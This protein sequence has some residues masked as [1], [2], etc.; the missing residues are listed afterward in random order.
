[1]KEKYATFEHVCKESLESIRDITEVK[2]LPLSLPASEHRRPES[3][4]G[5][6]RRQREGDNRLIKHGKL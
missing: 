6:S 1:M 3:S 4:M 2:K 5:T